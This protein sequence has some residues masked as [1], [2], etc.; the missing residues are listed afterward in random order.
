MDTNP[1]PPPTS[2]DRPSST[3]TVLD[4]WFGAAVWCETT[5]VGTVCGFVCSALSPHLHEIYVRDDARP[6]DEHPVALRDIGDTDH[7]DVVVNLSADAVE[8][9]V[10]AT[11][12]ITIDDVDQMWWAEVE[13]GTYDEWLLHPEPVRIPVVVPHLEHGD[14][15]VRANTDVYVERHHVG[16][17]AG[18]QADRATGRVTAAIIDVGHRWHHRHVLVPAAAIDELSE[19]T[20]WLRGT[21][22]QITHLPAPHDRDADDLAPPNRTT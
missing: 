20:V 21:R 8:A 11:D 16:R 9:S 12:T 14:V 22:Q 4:L 6:H 1:V 3:D 19:Q 2:D 13:S 5:R 10:C 7:H 18:L 15:L 17:L